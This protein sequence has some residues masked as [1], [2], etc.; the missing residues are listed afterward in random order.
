MAEDA[1]SPVRAQVFCCPTPAPPR[2]GAAHVPG[3]PGAGPLGSLT[4]QKAPLGGQ[5]LACRGLGS[6]TFRVLL[7][8]AKARAG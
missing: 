6:S 5:F 1:G 4:I 2:E 3:M 8:E 7:R